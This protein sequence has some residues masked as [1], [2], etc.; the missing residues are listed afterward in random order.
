MT[1]AVFRCRRMHRVGEGVRLALAGT[2]SLLRSTCRRHRPA[3][4][5]HPRNRLIERKIFAQIGA[6]ELVRR[7]IQAGPG[8]FFLGWV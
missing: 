5:A 3:D 7:E 2:G 6:F 8:N 1:V 4:V